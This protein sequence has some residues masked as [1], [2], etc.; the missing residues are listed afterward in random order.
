LP[1][2]VV[3]LSVEHPS[4]WRSAVLR[5]ALAIADTGIPVIRYFFLVILLFSCLFSLP[6]Y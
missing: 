2:F 4:G 3:I 5:V 1:F 6:Y